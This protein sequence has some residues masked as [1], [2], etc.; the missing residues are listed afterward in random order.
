M[1]SILIIVLI[2]VIG[3]FGF[4]YW[5]NS[6]TPQLGH[7]GGQLKPLSSNPNGVSTQTSDTDKLVS[8]WGFK[9][10]REETMQALVIAVQEYGGAKVVRQEDDYLY[11]IFTTPLMRFHDDAEFYLDTDSRLVHFR[12]AS[13]AGKSDMGLNRKRHEQLAELYLQADNT[14]VQR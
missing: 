11:V 1:K 10:S 2:L 12:S 8:P 14:S 4:I 13:R 7:E 5:Q 9:D 6:R 3:A